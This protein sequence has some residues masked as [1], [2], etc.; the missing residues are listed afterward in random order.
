MPRIAS[1]HEKFKDWASRCELRLLLDPRCARLLADM[2]RLTDDAA[3]QGRVAHW[4]PHLRGLS[5]LAASLEA[6]P[7]EPP[8]WDDLVPEV[9][10]LRENHAALMPVFPVMHAQ[11]MLNAGQAHYNAWYLSRVLRERGRPS[12]IESE[13]A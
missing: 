13:D 10:Y 8:A 3:R 4:A 9:A 7:A 1:L 6:R 11:R 5:R 2:R 12:R